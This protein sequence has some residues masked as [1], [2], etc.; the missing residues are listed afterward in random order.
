MHFFIKILKGT[1]IGIS[2]V[3]PGVSGGSMAMSM[4]I[5]DQLIDFITVGKESKGKGKSLL[6]YALGVALGV[7]LFSYFIEIMLSKFPLR[8]TCLFIG[9]ILGALPM[10]LK[11]VYGQRFRFS[12]ALI[13]L[14]TVA[15]MVFLPIATKDGG[16]VAH[17]E[18][19][20]PY[21]MLSLLLGCLAAIT[22]IVPGISGSMLLM[23][24]GY[25]EPVLQTVNAFSMALIKM[26]AQ[27]LLQALIILIPFGIGV[28]AGMI[29][30]ARAIRALLRY[31]PLSSYYGIIGL[32]LASPFAVL[33]QQDFSAANVGTWMISIAIS[34]VG[35]L[36]A[37][38]LGKGETS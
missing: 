1:L 3:I 21:A 34:A 13:L 24:L 15:V 28:I 5:Y 22:M 16:S 23:L 36:F 27:A 35:F 8:T 26:Q 17:L 31:F 4:G 10:L 30:M 25:Y 7:L 12:H 33:Y 19:T 14:S 11:N 6:P 2:V 38:L 32:V 37:M 29:F 18:P 20:F 9:M